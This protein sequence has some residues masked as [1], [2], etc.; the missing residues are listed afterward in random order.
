M[1]QS[2]LRL[3]VYTG[4]AVDPP[5]DLPL[6][7]ADRAGGETSQP[8]RHREVPTADAPPD[9]SLREAGKFHD[10]RCSHNP[11]YLK[12]PCRERSLLSCAHTYCLIG[13][14]FANMRRDAIET[15][16]WSVSSV[17]R[18]LP[19]TAGR[20]FF[21]RTYPICPALACASCAAGD[22]RRAYR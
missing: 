22:L 10:L 11:V 14:S 2:L 7:P 21:C 4:P 17:R 18:E 8:H 20:F 1:L 6:A 5:L 19:T 9:R 12:S 16:S 15:P 13:N 3:A